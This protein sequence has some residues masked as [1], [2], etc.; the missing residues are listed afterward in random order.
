MYNQ[1]L[2]CFFCSSLPLENF[3]ELAKFVP[4]VTHSWPTRVEGINLADDVLRPAYARD[5]E[6][7]KG[8]ILYLHFLICE[9]N[10]KILAVHVP[11]GTNYR[12]R[13]WSVVELKITQCKENN[14]LLMISLASNDNP[15]ELLHFSTSSL[16]WSLEPI[17]IKVLLWGWRRWLCETGIV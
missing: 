10:M 11:H 5:W 4:G 17:V 15:P 3:N 13:K 1:M 6:Q 7:S 9:I 8:K 16:L 12:D 2:P 14:E